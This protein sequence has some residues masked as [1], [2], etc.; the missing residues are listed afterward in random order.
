MLAHRTPGPAGATSAPA[1]ASAE[2][3]ATTPQ[4]SEPAFPAPPKGAVV[5]SRPDG[6]DVLALGV[7]PG[8]RLLLQASVLG[9]QGEG[10]EGLDVSF[11]V[12][13]KTLKGDP[14]G[15]GLLP[16]ESAFVARCPRR[17]TSAWPA[18]SR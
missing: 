13:G 7:V 15:A 12:G 3:S 4:T 8:K 11:G 6:N 18:R 5:F 2:P 17:S 9:G 16:G 14:C 10:V 1:S